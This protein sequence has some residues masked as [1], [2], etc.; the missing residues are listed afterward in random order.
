L[1]TSKLPLVGAKLPTT[2]SLFLPT[3]TIVYST[4]FRSS[5]RVGKMASSTARKTAK[6]YDSTWTEQVDQY[7]QTSFHC[8]YPGC[9][10]S[11]RCEPFVSAHASVSDS[12]TSN[13]TM[14]VSLTDEDLQA[15]IFHFLKIHD[16]QEKPRLGCDKCLVN[17]TKAEVSALFSLPI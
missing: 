17:A 12:S 3:P 13:R 7:G 10:S 11:R 16:R 15:V 8:T 5:L 4:P 2:P 9:K 14:W 6:D 1:R